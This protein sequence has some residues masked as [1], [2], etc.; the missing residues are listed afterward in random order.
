MYS[1]KVRLSLVVML[2]GT[3]LIITQNWT[4]AHNFLSTNWWNS[5]CWWQIFVSFRIKN[6]TYLVYFVTILT[7]SLTLTN[8]NKITFIP[9][10]FPP[11]FDKIFATFLGEM[12][13]AFFV[14]IY[15]ILSST[16]K[17]PFLQIVLAVQVLKVI[18]HSWF[19]P[20]IKI[21]FK[22]AAKI[23][24]KFSSVKV[25]TYLHVF[26]V[27]W[28]SIVLVASTRYLTRRTIVP[29]I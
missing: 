23:A 11:F 13:A 14:K 4:A 24:T 3:E 7:L 6:L 27:F 8:I 26:R 10:N 28:V 9:G 22:I 16:S 12:L 5:L 29:V 19:L 18:F 15:L 25:S 2:L 20:I 17:K 1:I 21:A